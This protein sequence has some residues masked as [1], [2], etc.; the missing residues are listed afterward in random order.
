MTASLKPDKT[1]RGALDLAKTTWE[2]YKTNFSLF[3][4]YSAWMLTPM[5]LNTLVLLTFGSSL[6]VLTSILLFAFDLIIIC[7]VVISI[8]KTANAL[9]K[10]TRVNVKK[11]S[12]QSWKLIVPILL[13]GLINASLTII[14]L[15]LLLIPGIIV[16]VMLTFSTTILVLENK[17]VIESIKESYKL[18]KGRFLQILGRIV[19]GNII[20]LVPYFLIYALIGLLMLSMNNWDIDVFVNAPPTLMEQILVRVTDII[21]LP[22][23]IIFG[24]MLYKT[25]KDSK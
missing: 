6:S 15:L 8:I 14:G 12:S 10:N 25:A 21:F 11:I 20:F 9:S 17:G 5:I 2:L 1:L 3:V 22:V 19:I 24:V 13:L 4:G 7:W 23:L 16:S 18:V